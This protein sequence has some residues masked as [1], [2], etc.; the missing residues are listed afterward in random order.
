MT[1][2]RLTLKSRL[3]VKS[4]VIDFTCDVTPRVMMT[5]GELTCITVE[6]FFRGGRLRAVQ[7]T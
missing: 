2:P 4:R 7:V 3:T 5:E 1:L 6:G